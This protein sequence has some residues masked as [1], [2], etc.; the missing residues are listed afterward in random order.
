MFD[1]ILRK[2]DSSYGV[3]SVWARNA[4]ISIKLLIAVTNVSILS[5]TT[6]QNMLAKED[7]GIVQMRIKNTLKVL[8]DFKNLREKGKSR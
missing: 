3:A 7:L 5:W 1:S 4:V 6:S 8:G 2:I